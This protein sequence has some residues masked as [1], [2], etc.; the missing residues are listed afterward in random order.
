MKSTGTKWIPSVGL[1]NF[2]IVHEKSAPEGY[3]WFG[4]IMVTAEEFEELR[5]SLKEG[6]NIDI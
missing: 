5:N 2:D 4:D 3:K 6:Y 1:V